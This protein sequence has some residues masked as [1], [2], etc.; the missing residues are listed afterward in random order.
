[1]KVEVEGNSGERGLFLY[2]GDHVVVY[3]MI[4]AY[5]LGTA[6]RERVV[7]VVTGTE[8][9]STHPPPSTKNLYSEESVSYELT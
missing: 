9:K 8:D 4:H 2:T 1:M 3:V 5:G 6:S 7:I